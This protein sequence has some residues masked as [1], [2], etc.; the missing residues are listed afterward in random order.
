VTW[1]PTFTDLEQ[2]GSFYRLAAELYA[3]CSDASGLANTRRAQADLAYRLDN[4]AAA[5]QLYREAAQPYEQLQHIQS[6][7]HTRSAQANL[8]FHRYDLAEAK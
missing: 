5:E 6:L 8:A 1:P 3:Q 4:Q 2:A 7:A